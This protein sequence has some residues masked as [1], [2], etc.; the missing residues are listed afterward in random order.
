M[1]VRVLETM[2]DHPNITEI[3]NGNF[4]SIPDG[5]YYAATVGSEDEASTIIAYGS[6]SEDLKY[7]LTQVATKMAHEYDRAHIYRKITDTK[8]AQY[9]ETWLGA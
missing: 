9:V 8:P 5:W 3:A 7:Y 6:T 2:V 1:I 4:W